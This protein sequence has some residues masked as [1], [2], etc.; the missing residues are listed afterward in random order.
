MSEP[1][2]SSERTDVP[3]LCPLTRIEP[4]R[5]LASAERP[6]A[7]IGQFLL[8]INSSRPV[9]E[10]EHLLRRILSDSADDELHN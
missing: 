1:A 8:A 3:R 7:V 2:L 4:T 6:L 9:A 5:V 10:C